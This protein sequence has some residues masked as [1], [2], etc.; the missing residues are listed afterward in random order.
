MQYGERV[1][2]RVCT[3]RYLSSN[4][5]SV[6]QQ[7]DYFH[8]HILMHG[9]LVQRKILTKENNDKYP[10]NDSRLFLKKIVKTKDIIIIEITI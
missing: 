7:H 6:F 3:A 2:S 5:L 10:K 9:Y 8:G 1:S 4:N